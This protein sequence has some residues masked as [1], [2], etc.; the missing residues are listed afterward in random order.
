[1]TLTIPGSIACAKAA[2]KIQPRT[3]VETRLTTKSFPV[4]GTAV[5][6]EC[7]QRWRKFPNLAT[8]VRELFLSAF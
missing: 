7:N 6:E 1:M 2:M 5:D 8:S 4:V 3:N